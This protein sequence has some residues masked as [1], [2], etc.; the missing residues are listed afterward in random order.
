MYIYFVHFAGATWILRQHPVDDDPARHFAFVHFP[1][2]SQCSHPSWDLE[3]HLQGAFGINSICQQPYYKH[4]I[5]LER[6]KFCNSPQPNPSI[7]IQRKSLHTLRRFFKFSRSTKRGNHS[8][9][10]Y[11]LKSHTVF[12]WIDCAHIP[13]D[14]AIF[15]HC[16]FAIIC[17][18]LALSVNRLRTNMAAACI[19]LIL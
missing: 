10:M 1:S 15:I 7:R 19:I 2:L 14:D 4:Q 9:W 12:N 5:V 8:Q 17:G 3:D 6:S 16:L 18:Y 11:A 13:D